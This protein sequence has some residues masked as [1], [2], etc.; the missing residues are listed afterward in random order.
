M[1]LRLAHILPIDAIETPRKGPY[2]GIEHLLPSID[3]IEATGTG[4]CTQTAFIKLFIV[5]IEAF[6][7]PL[8]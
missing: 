6:W 8:F 5:A 3:A 2:P 7:S 4:L 1:N